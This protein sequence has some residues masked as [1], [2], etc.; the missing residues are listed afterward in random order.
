MASHPRNFLVLITDQHRADHTGF[1][2]DPVVQTPH[3]DALAA[4]SVR[5]DRAY[6]A[7][8]IC[9]PNRSTLLTGRQP[10]VHGTRFNGVSLD[11]SANTFVRR[12]RAAG[13]RTS[14]IGKSHLQN[15]RVSRSSLLRAMDFTLTEEARTPA[16]ADWDNK[17]HFLRYRKGENPEVVDFYGY[18]RALFTILHGDVVCQC[19]F[20]VSIFNL[21]RE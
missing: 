19:H 17:E 4:R 2:G 10:S 15:M 1:G 11:E 20:A 5:F 14:H 9:M 7:N 3:L 8:P 21:D 6:V 12:L 16:P 13:Y 18:E